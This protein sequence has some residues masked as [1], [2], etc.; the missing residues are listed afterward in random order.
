MED[1]ILTFTFTQEQAEKIAKRI[2]S[3]VLP[4]YGIPIHKGFTIDRLVDFL[5]DDAEEALQLYGYFTV[6]L[7]HKMTITGNNHSILVESSDVSIE[8]ENIE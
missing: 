7:D 4:I 8:L 3:C 1:K 5:P 6:N 2:N